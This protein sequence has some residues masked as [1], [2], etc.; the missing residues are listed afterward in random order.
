MGTCDLVSGDEL[1]LGPPGVRPP[2]AVAPHR[3][4]A[5]DILAG[6][7]SGRSL[8]M[9][10]GA[11]RIGR[12][13][14]ADLV[15]DD[16]SVSRHHADAIVDDDWDVT[17]VPAP[18][19]A[20]GVVVNDEPIEQ[21]AP[22]DGD[23]VVGLGG[24]RLAFRPFERSTDVHVDRLG[25][26]D[27][28][29]TPY[30]RPIVAE[31]DDVTVGPIPERPEPRKLQIF[32]MVA[33]LAAG[34]AM[35]AFTRQLQFL[36]LTAVSP[37][38]MMANVFEDRRSGR[39]RFRDQLRLFRT[40]VGEHRQ[41]LERLRHQERVERLRA[42]PDLADL[43]RRAELRTVDLWARGRTSPDFLAIRLGL[44]ESRVGY[45]IEL[46]RGGAGDLRDELGTAI[47][48][49]DRLDN[50]PITVDL[51]SDGVLGLHGERQLVDGVAASVAIQAATL[52]SPEDLTIVG[53]ISCDRSFGWLKWLPHVRSVASPLPGNHVVHDHTEASSV[54]ARLVEVA[55]FRAGDG[56]GDDEQRCWP[57][58]LLFLDADLAPDA[59][60]VSRLLDT[61]PAVGISVVWLAGTL[62]SIPRQA[63]QVLGVRRG[64]GA[65]MLGRLWSTDPDITDQELEVEHLRAQRADCVARALAP[66][67]D[68]STASL[69]TSIPRRAPLLDVLG[70]GRPSAE[71]V[72]ERWL[73]DTGYDLRFPIG[74]DADGPLEIDLVADGPHT[75][76]GG[77]SGAGKSEL[78][79]SMVAALAVQHPPSRLNFLFVDY[80]GGASSKVFESLPHTVGYVTNLSA[81]LSLRAL[82]SLRAELDRRMR[83]L[84]GRAKDL[85]EML[86][87]S[88]AEAP[89]SLVIIVDE[90]ATLVKE[91]PEFVAGI[92]DIAQRGRSLGIHL[93]LATQRPS[94]SVNENIL[95]NTNL[96]ISLRMLDRSESTSVIG[97]P[98]AADIPVPLKGRGFV[99]L[100]PRQLVE[101]QS[102]FAGAPL[103]AADELQPI[104]IAP[105]D[106]TDDSPRSGS[107]IGTAAGNDRIV[108]H[109][110]VVIDAIVA[111]NA[112]LALPT[113]RR[114]WREML[115]EVI[116]LQSIGSGH[117]TEVTTAH[118]GRFVTIGLLDA[119]ETQDQRPAVIDLEDGGGCL[120]F[121]SG[122]SGKTTLLRTVAA[123]ISATCGGDDVD[124]VAIVGFD[125][126]SRGLT[127]IKPLPEVVDVATGDDLEAVTRHLTMLDRE[128]LRRRRLLAEVGAEHLTAYNRLQP[129]LPRIVVLIDGFGAMAATFINAAGSIGGTSM[130]VWGELIQRL[131]IDGRQAGI[132][133]V[134]TADRFN[135]VPSRIHSAVSCRIVLRHADVSAYSEHGISTERARNLDLPPG[136]G[137]L[138][139]STL[140][141]IA[142]VSKD[143]AAKSQGDRIVSFADRLGRER[144]SVLASVR[145]PSA[146]SL[147]QVDK[148]RQ[149]RL[150]PCIGVSDVQ[151]EPVVV[152]LE[153]SN[154]TVCGAPRSGRSTALATVAR[155]LADHEVHVVG[156]ASSPLGGL[157][158]GLPSGAVTTARP[159]Q[160]VDV[161]DRLANLAAMG[162]GS[163]P[164][165]LLI[166][167]VDRLD[168]FALTPVWER[169]AKLD[170]LRI[171]ATMET[172]SMS[173][174][175]QN[176]LMNVLRRA[177]RL[178]VLRPDDPTDFLAATG[179]KLSIRPGTD[180]PP[181]RGVLL[182]DRVPSV[183]HVALPS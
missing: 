149:E 15:I 80:K 160:L 37:I 122:G 60:E 67:R 54:V 103:V 143:P 83:V 107:E 22:V 141:Q 20:N 47:D 91:V 4:I 101:F 72:S 102:S 111:A 137:L 128:L 112:S 142:S 42:A 165:V 90:F 25:Q 161:L 85:A 35:Y 77:T 78:L 163:R 59:V 74:F 168:D 28:H 180:L 33:P 39:V 92:V 55:A 76:I 100:G 44:G 95:A 68:A 169:L 154:L 2:V 108:T 162:P 170:D 150:R 110:S 63:S 173:G 174:Y 88:P 152:D 131:V 36:A 61:G 181:G 123:S 21:A 5:A 50:V 147:D 43:S 40:Q 167:D 41:R 166:D 109:L 69:A 156:P 148:P 51:T 64:D 73:R 6:P 124:D 53:A 96:R 79:Q 93:V 116:T 46:E 81:D 138:Q 134:S 118:P 31:R 71:W 177:P 153:W 18:G 82:T 132:H 98:E 144:T 125:F 52:H 158:L 62:A 145:L 84:E 94:G 130:E 129:S 126:A 176:P 32:G 65:A 57:R 133:T 11:Y 13:D 146:I 75:L 10:P 27:F 19:T 7:E 119:P 182:V 34:L 23:D 139:G 172:R 120:V 30:R 38:V 114:P 17:V 89:P 178:L 24:S 113:P 8:L 58:I 151:G 159:D 171:V 97:T 9:L 155:S 87:K 115:P 179:V 127:S 66:I 45:A 1:V 29:R 49:L 104:L 48:D 140:V 135:A 99:R 26:I 16:P 3:A 183:V 136:R 86:E 121:G 157:D 105:Y 117:G 12:G 70:V 106:R 14:D 56:R 175:T 164:R